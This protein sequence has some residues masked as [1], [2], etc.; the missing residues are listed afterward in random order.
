MKAFFASAA[1]CG[2][3]CATAAPAMAGPYVS[4][5]SEFKG[6]DDNYKSTVNQARLGYDWKE[7]N[8]KPY[9][10]LGGGAS[11]AD[12]G[13][14]KTF[15]AAEIGTAVKLTDNLSAKVKGEVLSFD[16]KNDW[17]VEVSTKYRF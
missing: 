9:V 8:L 17:K 2:I 12:A 15:V 10:E 11:T 16:T 13:D 3:A 6:T 14:T 4:T 5:K 7:G 1:L